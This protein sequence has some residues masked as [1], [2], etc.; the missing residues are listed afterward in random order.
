MK[1]STLPIYFGLNLAYPFIIFYE[2]STLPDYQKKRGR[3]QSLNDMKY[4]CSFER[5]HNGGTPSIMS[6]EIVSGRIGQLYSMT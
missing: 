6:V 4:V 2:N 3:N 5:G 1:S